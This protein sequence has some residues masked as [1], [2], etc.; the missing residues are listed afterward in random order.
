MDA[1]AIPVIAISLPIILVPTVLAMKHARRKRE[2]EHL[3]RMK[4]LE[5][6]HRLPQHHAWSAFAATAIGAGV[7]IAAFLLA[8][9]ASLTTHVN[10]D[11]WKG[12]TFVGI[13]GVIGGTTLGWL[14]LGRRDIPEP[15]PAEY[16]ASMNG[17]HAMDP[18]AYDVAGQRG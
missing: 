11:V 15:P 16:T 18:D 4:A 6:G 14:L 17:K 12:A 5:M 10:D 1:T 2:Y 8:W 7:P 13:T 9:L 3:E